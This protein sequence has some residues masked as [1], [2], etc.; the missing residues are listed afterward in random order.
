MSAGFSISCLQ[1]LCTVK[2][3]LKHM[4]YVR[5]WW[6]RNLMN[7]YFKYEYICVRTTSLL[8]S[9]FKLQSFLC[10]RIRN[11]ISCILKL[12]AWNSQALLTRKFNVL[13]CFTYKNKWQ[14]YVA[15][16]HV[17]LNGGNITRDILYDVSELVWLACYLT[18]LNSLTWYVVHL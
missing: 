7:T 18:T 4:T 11:D 15:L 5:T 17:Y 14:I 8:H 13:D 6:S 10:I 9:W 3:F 16:S 2:L 1:W 12:P